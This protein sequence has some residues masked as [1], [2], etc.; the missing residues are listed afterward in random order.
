MAES[1]GAPAAPAE[2]ALLNLIRQPRI[3]LILLGGW[4]IAAAVAEAFV[5]A[6]L[7]SPFDGLVLGWQSIPLA[8]LYLYCARDPVRYQRVF[9]LALVHQAATIAANFYHWGAGDLELGAVIFPVAVAAGLALLVFL[10]LF[11]PKEPA[12]AAQ[13]RAM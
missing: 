9:W 6:K 5:S 1:L 4:S 11:Q 10:H 13:G 3:M 2:N 7:D 12:G 8:V